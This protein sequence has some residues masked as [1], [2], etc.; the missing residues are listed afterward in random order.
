MRRGR[1]ERTLEC[2]DY[3][4]NITHPL[5]TVFLQAAPQHRDHP[6]R[7]GGRQR[8]PVGVT[9]QH[10]REH[11]RHGLAGEH[12]VAR[13]H[14]QDDDAEGPHVTAFVDRFTGGL[15]GAHVG[16][17]A[18]N[19]PLLRAMD[20][21]RRGHRQT[22]RRTRGGLHGLRQPE[23]EH[24]H[25]AVGTNLNIRR[26]EIAVDDPLLVRTF[27][28]LGDLLRDQQRFVERNCA[29]RNALRQI[30]TLDKFH[31]QRRHGA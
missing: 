8:R 3:V 13:Q 12:G 26:L 6:R 2:E 27:E 25:R 10:G 16:S 17:R 30:V 29:T 14:F 7:D 18:E 9:L 21:A 11:M 28:R 15:L 31:H 1:L 19:D 23:V 4:A 20:R 24:L 5:L 22:R